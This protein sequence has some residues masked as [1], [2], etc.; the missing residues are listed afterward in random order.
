M[1]RILTESEKTTISNG[2]RVA[3]ERFKGH[4]QELSF[5][6]CPSCQ[7]RPGKDGLGRT[8]KKCG[9]RGEIRATKPGYK[10]LALQFEHQYSDSIMLAQVI[11]DAAHVALEI[12]PEPP[13][14]D[15]NE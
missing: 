7:D 11:D 12:E 1:N 8:C 3:A 2:L 13:E 15:G 9:G 5:E 14:G 4:V 10:S 6:D